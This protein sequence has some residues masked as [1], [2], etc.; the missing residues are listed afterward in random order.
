MNQ[1]MNNYFVKLLIHNH[2]TITSTSRIICYS[3]IK[4]DRII[5]VGPANIFISRGTCLYHGLIVLFI[6]MH[7]KMS[8]PPLSLGYVVR[9]RAR[10]PL[11]GETVDFDHN[12]RNE[13]T[14]AEMPG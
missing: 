10:D 14:L 4:Y 5:E 6:L 12:F 9:Q 3:I 1:I 8:K 7:Q 2:I 11:A 13:A